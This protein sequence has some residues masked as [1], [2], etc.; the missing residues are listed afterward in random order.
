MHKP[1]LLIIAML[2]LQACSALDFLPPTNT[3][4]PSSTVTNTPTMTLTPTRTTTPTPRDTVTP[5]G[6]VPT[7]TPVVLVS[8]DLDAPVPDFIATPDLPTGG[9]ESVSLSQGKIFYGSCKQNYIKMTITVENPVEVDTV[10]LFFRLESGKRPGDTTPWSGAV[11][12][13]DGGGVFHYTLRARN[14]PERKNFIK[15]WVHY[16]FVAVDED[17]NILGRSQIYT[18]NLILEPCK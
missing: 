3:P 16:Q 17:K 6:A 11:T 13:K 9:F 12:D 7:F 1:V 10:Y 15:A 4:I 5:I 14:I 2:F 18:R 8:P